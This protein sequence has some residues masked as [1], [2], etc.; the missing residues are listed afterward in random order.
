MRLVSRMI[1]RYDMSVHFAGR[2]PDV[3]TR[4]RD[5]FRGRYAISSAMNE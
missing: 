5:R 4:T 2:A 1:M 3:L